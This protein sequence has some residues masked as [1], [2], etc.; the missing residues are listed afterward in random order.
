MI[1]HKMAVPLLIGYDTHAYLLKGAG[2]ELL[3]FFTIANPID[4]DTVFK[5][6][7]K[8]GLAPIKA[9]PS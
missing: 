6:T 9:P 8:F 1:G 2:P 4:V 7:L 3:R 5:G